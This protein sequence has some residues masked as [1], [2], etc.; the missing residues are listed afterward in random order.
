MLFC[1]ENISN[2]GLVFFVGG[3]CVAKLSFETTLKFGNEDVGEAVYSVSG[4][5]V[6]EAC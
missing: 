4:S 6:L 1:S 2:T 3:E 5:D